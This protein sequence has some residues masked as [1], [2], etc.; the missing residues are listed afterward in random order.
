MWLPG[1]RGERRRARGPG[2]GGDPLHDPR[3]G[4]DRGGPPARRRRRRLGAA[5]AGG[6]RGARPDRARPRRPGAARHRAGPSG[7]GTRRDPELTVDLVVYDGALAHALAFARPTSDDIVA[8]AS[9]TPDDGWP[10]GGGHR[11]RDLRPPPPGCRARGRPRPHGRRAGRAASARPRLVD[12]LDERP[13]THEARVPRQ[14]LVVRPRRGPLEDR[15]RV[16]HRWR[17]RAGRRRGGR[18]CA[19]PSTCCATGGSSWSSGA[20][21]SLLRDPW[22]A[23]DAY[24]DRPARRPVVG[25]LR[26][27]A[28]RRRRTIAGAAARRPAQRPPHVHVVRL[29][30]QRPRRHRDGAGAALRGPGHRPLPAAR[31]VAA[32]GRRPRRC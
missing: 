17:R 16:P 26:R 22:A 29:V 13:P 19:P 10:G 18:R 5:R 9:T 31:R 1:D 6:P 30:L 32:R 25:R 27:R 24:L 7:G 3:P 14:R 11:R 23:R 20:G 2:R 8:A 21:P 15:L 28:R 12:L 4:S